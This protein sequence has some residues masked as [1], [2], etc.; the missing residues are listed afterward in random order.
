MPEPW[1]P[2]PADRSPARSNS[3]PVSANRSNLR[4]DRALALQ[5]TGAVRPLAELIESVDTDAGRDRVR[6]TLASLPF[7]H[8]EACPDRPG[9]LVKIDADG[10]RTRGRFVNRVFVESP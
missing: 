7:P 5:R 4:G 10:T 1:G 3:G 2:W 6:T 9:M 8:F